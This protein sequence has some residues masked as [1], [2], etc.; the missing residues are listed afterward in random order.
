MQGVCG[1]EARDR[2]QP[3]TFLPN[4]CT[5]CSRPLLVR[6]FA[7][8][9]V[10]F[11]EELGSDETAVELLLIQLLDCPRSH[12]RRFIEDLAAAFGHVC[13]SVLEYLGEPHV[14]CSSCKGSE[15][16][17]IDLGVEVSEENAG[18]VL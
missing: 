3:G 11:A 16:S 1:L 8:L 4:V 5:R 7:L 18:A 12:L 13:I 2:Q 15:R 10:L 6:L 17:L 9:A 14:A